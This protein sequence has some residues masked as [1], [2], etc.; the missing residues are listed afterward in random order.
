MSEQR[1]QLS[2]A[3]IDRAFEAGEF[4]VLYQPKIDIQ[5]RTVVGTEA[6][7]RWRHPVL[8]EIPPGMFLSYMERQGRMLEM[9]KHVLKS[10]A[11]TAREWRASGHTPRIF[12][13]FAGGDLRDT[14]LPDIL[15]I[16]MRTHEIDGAQ[17][18]M[19]IPESAILRAGEAGLPTLT[20]LRRR[21][22]ALALDCAAGGDPL[23]PSESLAR[24]TEIK[25]GG[26]AIIRFSH[27]I[28]HIGFGMIQNRI[29][30]AEGLGIP[31]TAV[32]VE[33]GAIVPKLLELGIRRVQGNHFCA[34]VTEAR[35]VTW[36]EDWQRSE[37]ERLPVPPVENPVTAQVGQLEEAFSESLTIPSPENAI[38]ETVR[39]TSPPGHRKLP[40]IEKPI[41]LPDVDSHQD[42]PG[43]TLWQKL[44]RRA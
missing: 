32:G 31:V 13:N 21:G 20:A 22:I 42:W 7:V 10:A 23:T 41:A 34:P 3:D 8:G 14:Y 37:S 16:L 39:R 4:F 40:N 2:N 17:L 11:L 12:V 30:I 6:F 29:A 5:T 44:I 25:I 18:G 35:F 19:D 27:H 33:D 24:F 38:P 9:T 26:E 28:R 36:L 43:R 15:D 1:F